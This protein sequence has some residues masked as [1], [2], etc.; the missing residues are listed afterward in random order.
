M[1]T[2]KY[3]LDKTTTIESND[4]AL[5]YKLAEKLYNNRQGNHY[6]LFLKNSKDKV[7]VDWSCSCYRGLDTELPSF[8]Y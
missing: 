5:L 6:Q 1:Y 7:I 3:I 2:L 4:L 8:K